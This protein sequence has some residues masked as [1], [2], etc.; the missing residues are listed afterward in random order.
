MTRLQVVDYSPVTWRITVRLPDITSV[1]FNVSCTYTC[2]LGG[3]MET[4][5][6]TSSFYIRHV[7]I[8]LFISIKVTSHV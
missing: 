1:H 4:G 2:I 6:V 5:R 7:F 8:Y 3:N